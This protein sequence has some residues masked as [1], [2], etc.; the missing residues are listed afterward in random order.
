MKRDR[1]LD[2][3]RERPQPQR[4]ITALDF[5]S[6]DEA[7]T[8]AR[9]LGPQGSF[10]KVGLELFST[11]GPEVLRLLQDLD[12]QVFL[13]LKYHDIPNTV[14]G[15]A[16]VAAHLGAA[17]VTIHAAAGRRAL[18][19]AADALAAAAGPG[20]PR[21]ALLAVT[22][23]TSLTREELDE[24]SPTDG[25]V[26]DRVERLARLAWEA[27]CDGVVCAAPDL[28]LLRNAIGSAPLVVTPGI[29]PAAA[30]SDDQRRTATPAAAVAA[31]ADFLVVGRPI[32]RAPDPAAA[33]AEL[34]QDLVA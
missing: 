27:G 16:R 1:L 13:D 14:A 29:R 26:A 15:A 5:S 30:G 7:V 32:T 20:G 28:A 21:P 24:V 31:G 2:L 6:A 9:Q 19:A 33:L 4:I 25:D 34:G 3:L 10:V 18:A 8:L 22:I 17:M 12:K 11:A 23:L